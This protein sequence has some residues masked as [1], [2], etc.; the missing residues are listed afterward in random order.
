MC[1]M[2][3]HVKLHR[4]AL[5]GNRHWNEYDVV[6]THRRKSVAQI[7][8]LPRLRFEGVHYSA[9]ADASPHPIGVRA[10][11]TADIDGDLARP[12]T[13][14]NEPDL[15]R[16]D[17]EAVAISAIEVAQSS[18]HGGAL[19]ASSR[20]RCNINQSAR[21][22]SPAAFASQALALPPTNTKLALGRVRTS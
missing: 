10:F 5:V 11:V 18:R 9:W 22:K 15:A 8:N 6:V 16:I 13:V 19:S 1:G 17:S 2:W 20:G 12:K 3:R 14:A 21:D 4:A 7:L